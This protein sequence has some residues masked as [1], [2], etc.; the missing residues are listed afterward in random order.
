[1]ADLKAL[2]AKNAA[3]WRAVKA[4]RNFATIAKRLV[5]QKARYQAVAATTC[6][7]WFIIA[8]IHM[9]ESSQDFSRSLAQGDPWNRKSIHVPQ[10][11]GPFAS[12]EAAAVDALTNCHPY[13]ARWKDWSPAG[14]MT[15][16]EQY[17]GLGYANKG[18]P[19][20]YIWAGTNQY[21]SGKYVADH[22]FDPNYVDTQPGCAGL[23]LAMKKI[24]PSIYGGAKP[25]TKAAGAVVAATVT[26]AATA[27]TGL[28]WPAIAA[29]AF[30]V[31]F[32]AFAIIH[33]ARKD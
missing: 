30:A 1:M 32:V 4:T 10:G 15:L 28:S 7:P 26:T 33:I 22:K 3:R 17:N 12:W 2:Q 31:A 5:A 16:L 27:Q 21:I 9:R 8:V 29:I 24:D 13:A 6:V 18:L 20:P 25:S 14:A 23:I 19:S 11:R